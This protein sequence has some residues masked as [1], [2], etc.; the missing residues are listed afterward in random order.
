MKKFYV[1]AVFVIVLQIFFFI[2]RSFQ[3]P[4]DADYRQLLKKYEGLR[5]KEAREQVN[6]DRSQISE[7]D[8]ERIMEQID[9]MEDVEHFHVTAYL[10]R[11]E[12]GYVYVEVPKEKSGVQGLALEKAIP[13]LVYREGYKELFGVGE[14]ILH[15]VQAIL[16]IILT[17]LLYDGK[18]KEML[19]RRALDAVFIGGIVYLPELIWIFAAYGFSGSEY[20]GISVGEIGQFAIYGVAR[21]MYAMRIFGIFVF[22]CLVLFLNRLL[23]NRRDR[24]RILLFVFYILPVLVGIVVALVDREQVFLCGFSDL[25][26][27]TNALKFDYEYIAIL[28]ILNI[29]IIAI[30]RFYPVYHYS[31]K[32]IKRMEQHFKG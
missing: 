9:W 12:K 7:K 8:F 2:G 31:E 13:L 28:L 25:L 30:C 23:R 15:Y 5:Y 29:V 24:I 3:Y 22:G 19:R 4:A 10:P 17:V 27:A 6:A 1:A 16:V 18:E 32:D 21:I 20:P 14:E 11:S 26:I